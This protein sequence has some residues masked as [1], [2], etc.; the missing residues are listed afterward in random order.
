LILESGNG[1][2]RK[3]PRFFLN[4]PELEQAGEGFTESPALA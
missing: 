4:R 2:D 1:L 3:V